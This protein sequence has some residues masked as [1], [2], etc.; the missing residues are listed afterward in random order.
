MVWVG[1]L[2]G[3]PRPFSGWAKMTRIGTLAARLRAGLPA[4]VG[5]GRGLGGGGGG[6]PFLGGGGVGV[7]HARR[8]TNTTR[9]F[10]NNTK[11]NKT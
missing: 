10:K 11:R 5:G 2:S 1:D 7:M 4:G 9:K 6:P 8:I 3:F